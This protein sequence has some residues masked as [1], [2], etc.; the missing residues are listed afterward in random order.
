MK[1]KTLL[2]LLF[3]LNLSSQLIEK[4][5]R[6]SFVKNYKVLKPI[7]GTWILVHMSTDD[8]EVDCENF[9]KSFIDQLKLNGIDSLELRTKFNN[10]CNSMKNHTLKITDKFMIERNDTIKICLDKQLEK[11]VIFSQNKQNSYKIQIINLN[12]NYFR[13]F[14]SEKMWLEFKR[15]GY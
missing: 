11:N 3:S 14:Y 6:I 2:L 4:N 13:F 12:E 1:L 8:M 5:E 7:K 10:S 9:E 15:K